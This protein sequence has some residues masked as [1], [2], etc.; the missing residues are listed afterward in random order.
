VRLTINGEDRDFHEVSSI[1]G[2]LDRLSLKSDRVA[3]ELNRE[4][5]ARDKWTTTTLAD[6][7]KLEI[8]HFVGGG[9][10]SAERSWQSGCPH[11]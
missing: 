1:A 8:V 11:G 10:R 7:D 9:S 4:L 2:L 6:G 3:V 5:V